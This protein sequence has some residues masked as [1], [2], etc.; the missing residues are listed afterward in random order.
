METKQSRLSWGG[1][2]LLL[3]GFCALTGFLLLPVISARAS[4]TNQAFVR[5]IHSSPFVGTA[6]VFVDG[7]PFLTSFAFGAV[8]SYAAVPPGPHK[9]QIALV[10]KGVGAA[11]LTETLNVQPGGV[12]TIAA[13]GTAP[14]NLNLLVFKDDNK[15]ASGTARLRVYQLAPN[16]GWMTLH[17]GNESL[18]GV[19]YQQASSYLTMDTGASSF[20]MAS[21]AKNKSLSLNATL[22]ANTV[23]SIFAV[24]MFNG[25]PGARLVSAQVA[26]TPGM[27]DT[28]SDPAPL[29]SNGQWSTPWLLVAL[30]LMAIGG[31]LFTRRLLSS[32][33]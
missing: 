19:N 25:T 3:S 23:T 31:T 21:T 18:A 20:S 2:A 13:I 4:T 8:T 10:G 15:A 14:T 11:A 9:V 30:T 29:P 26:A 5:I 22:K 28:G 6:D 1:L 17:D 27:P 24:G 32:R 7:N 12:Y 16:G 33:W